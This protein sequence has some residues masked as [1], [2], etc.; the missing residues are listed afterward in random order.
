MTTIQKSVDVSA[1]VRSA[2][3]QWTQFESF[4]NFMEGVDEITQQTPTRTHW[5]TSIGGVVREFDAEITEQH[6]DERIA[7]HTVTGPAH[8]GVVTFHRLDDTTTRVHLQMEYEPESLT[9]KAGT[10]LGVVDHRIKADLDRFKHFI[11]RRDGETGQ[12]RGDVARPPQQGEP[13]LGGRGGTSARS[14]P[15]TAADADADFAGEHTRP[16]YSDEPATESPD[17]SVPRGRG[18][19]G[20]MDIA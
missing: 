9:E 11:E 17:E 3:N 4:P 16:T 14:V 7:W 5:K 10:A 8:A 1:P 6:P 13:H 15:P 20:G 12:W 18:G 19:A 2:Y